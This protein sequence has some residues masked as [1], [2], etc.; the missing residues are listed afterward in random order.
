MRFA[1]VNLCHST[2]T[3]VYAIFAK[4]ILE[5]RFWLSATRQCFSVIVINCCAC[6]RKYFACIFCEKLSCYSPVCSHSLH[7]IFATTTSRLVD[8]LQKQWRIFLKFWCDYRE[9]QTYSGKVWRCCFFVRI[10][11]LFPIDFMFMQ[12]RFKTFKEQ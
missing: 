5:F 6:L 1:G 3:R 12:S 8:R 10:C 9:V 2:H 7:F 4:I 11:I